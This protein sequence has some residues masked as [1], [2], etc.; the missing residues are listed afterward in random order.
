MNN[1]WPSVGGKDIKV[2]NIFVICEEFTKNRI[3]SVTLVRCKMCKRVLL[4]SAHICN[5]VQ[6]NPS[7]VIELCVYEFLPF[8]GR[9]QVCLMN[10]K[11]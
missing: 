6:K 3:E 5:N 9:C 4:T 8:V 10:S 2:F 1:M 11:E 7:Q